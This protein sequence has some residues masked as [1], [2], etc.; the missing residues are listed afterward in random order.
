MDLSKLKQELIADEGLSTRLYWCP[1]GHATYGVG[2]NLEAN[3]L[4]HDQRAQGLRLRFNQAFALRLLNDDI[5]RLLDHMRIR[6][7]WVFRL[8]EPQQR[9]IANMA[10][11]LGIVGVLK[12]APTWGYLQAGDLA[13]VERRLRAAPWAKQTQSSRVERIIRLLKEAA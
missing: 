10:H 3:P 1:T 6:M 11:Q 7:P 12:F 5:G 4:T 2:H 13:E 8:P 9:A